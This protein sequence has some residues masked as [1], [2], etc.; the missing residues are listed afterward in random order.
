MIFITGELT[1]EANVTIN[2]D[3]END[4][5]PSIVSV[6][7]FEDAL[8]SNLSSSILEQLPISS[9]YIVSNDFMNNNTNISAAS[10]K[11]ITI[12]SSQQ[13][14]TL[15]IDSPVIIEVSETIPNSSRLIGLKAIDKDAGINATISYRL[16]G[17]WGRIEDQNLENSNRYFNVDTNTG[18][19]YAI[20][21][22]PPGGKF[23]LEL[24]AIDGGQ[25]TDNFVLG[26]IISDVNNHAP[27]FTKQNYRYEVSENDYS[28]HI[29][30]RVEA[31]DADFGDNGLVSYKLID[32][33]KNNMPLSVGEIDG[34]L[35]LS[36]HLDRETRTS[37]HFTVEAKDNGRSSLKSYATIELVIRDVNDNKPHFKEY[38]RLSEDGQ[39]P[40]YESTVR[41]DAA[42][43]T[44]VI[45]VNAHD[46]DLISNG[47]GL[48]VYSLQHRS[49]SIDPRSGRIAVT[50]DAY[51]DAQ[52]EPFIEIFITASDLGESP[53]SST[54]LLRVTVLPSPNGT[55]SVSLRR[56]VFSHRVFEL[57]VEENEQVPFVL[58]TLNVTE[59][60]KGR[61]LR[62]SI[63][64]E[65]E[66]DI[67][68]IDP[69]NGTLYLLQSLDREKQK[70]YQVTI[71]A[72]SAK[73]TRGLTMV[74]PPPA[75]TLAKLGIFFSY[76]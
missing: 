55:K 17:S 27:V 25:L 72:E 9:S 48:V 45:K 59:I 4:N 47:N 60:Y 28:N 32:E 51:L 2:I 12:F 64:Q 52:M 40:I 20:N 50:N 34:R 67:F 3:D 63:V 5:W 24:E 65:P 57:Q 54:A 66:S 15:N 6:Q 74:Y 73:K 41:E 75:E 31:H 22:L 10:G 7:I 62:Y 30:G 71:R 37:Y 8:L 58:I 43:G 14:H 21:P 35:S 33:E 1:S 53:Q 70:E 11:S 42:P 18:I 49:F 76:Y 44:P 23:W 61:R 19:L 56:P 69:W 38:T 16:V 39:T 46:A 68:S 26:L 36:G 13:N 29:L